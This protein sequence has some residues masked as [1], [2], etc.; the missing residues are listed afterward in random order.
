MLFILAAGVPGQAIYI[1]LGGARPAVMPNIITPIPQP[2]TP[3][4]ANGMYTISSFGRPA[5]E[6]A[7]TSTVCGG[8]NTV[9]L[10]GT[11]PGPTTTYGPS[12][13]CS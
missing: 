11:A 2:V 6:R 5:C 4:L 10:S 7:L 12:T 8:D 9:L 1:G 13:C 3:V